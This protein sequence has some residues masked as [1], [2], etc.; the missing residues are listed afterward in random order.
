MQVSEACVSGVGLTCDPALAQ[1]P[2]DT[3]KVPWRL[4]SQWPV[5]EGHTFP[6]PH[7]YLVSVSH[8]GEPGVTSSVGW[9]LPIT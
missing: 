9:S 6:N 8:S 3:L 2:V 5:R 7:Q 1:P 4:T